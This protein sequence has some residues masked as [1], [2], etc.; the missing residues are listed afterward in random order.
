MYVGPVEVLCA[1][2]L[3]LD[4]IIMFRRTAFERRGRVHTQVVYRRTFY[5]PDGH[6]QHVRRPQ[7]WPFPSVFAYGNVD[8]KKKKNQ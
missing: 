8:E 6:G 2:D 5:L 3:R 7:E 1:P 4:V